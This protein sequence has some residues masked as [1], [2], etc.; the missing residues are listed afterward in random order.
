MAVNYDFY[1]YIY[2]SDKVTAKNKAKE[3]ADNYVK[4]GEKV[5]FIF[6]LNKTNG[7]YHFV[8]DARLAPYTS[9]AYISTLAE[10]T[11]AKGVSAEAV[12]E[13]I[14]RVDST[15]MMT[16]DGDFSF[17]GQMPINKQASVEHIT[18]QNFADSME[19]GKHAEKVK[20]DENKTGEE[21]AASAT[22][23]DGEGMLPAIL[24]FVLAVGTIALFKI[25]KG[26][27]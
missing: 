25:K 19:L 8:E 3:I 5:P 10:E 27:R 6:V 24:A 20:K 4:Q 7:S 12:K 11:F 16:V 17:T 2:E 23:D 14:I 1:T 21:T 18:I 13:F 9:A 26:R 22:E 15:L